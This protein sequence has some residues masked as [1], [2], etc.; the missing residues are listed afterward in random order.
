MRTGSSIRH[1]AYDRIGEGSPALERLSAADLDRA[2]RFVGEIE[3]VEAASSFPTRMLTALKPL[4]SCDMAGYNE[5]DRSEQ[6]VVMVLDPDVH[7]T[8][9]SARVARPHPALRS[10]ARSTDCRALQISL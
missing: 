5:V 10:H 6:R 3:A 8:E 1:S 2:L 7:E 9:T 4:I